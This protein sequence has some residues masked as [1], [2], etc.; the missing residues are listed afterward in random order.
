[1][2]RSLEEVVWGLRAIKGCCCWAGAVVLTE[3]K[4]SYVGAPNAGRTRDRR[5]SPDWSFILTEKRVCYC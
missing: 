1:L 3:P 4:L 5:E 2:R